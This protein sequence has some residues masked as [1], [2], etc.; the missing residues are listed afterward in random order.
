MAFSMP[1]SA[2]TWIL[3]TWGGTGDAGTGPWGEVTATETGSGFDVNV[4]V[5]LYSPPTVGFVDTGGHTGFSFSLSSPADV[6]IQNLTAGF[7][8]GTTPPFTNPNFGNFTN[9]IFCTGCGSGGGA[10]QLTG[11]LSF[12]IHDTGGISLSSFIMSI[13]PPNGDTPALF[14]A[15]ILSNGFTGAV[16]TSTPAIP[17]PE[18]YAMMLVGFSLLAFVARRRKQSIGNVVPA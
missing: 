1:A 6:T 16:G 13:A 14:A 3:D 7:T 17:E 11:P 18:T 9:G 2:T 8:A 4:T 5:T 10:P 15:D 12:T